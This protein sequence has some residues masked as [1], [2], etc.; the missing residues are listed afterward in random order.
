MNELQLPLTATLDSSFHTQHP[1]LIQTLQEADFH[2]VYG[3]LG[4]ST[5]EIPPHGAVMIYTAHTLS[6]A[7]TTTKNDLQFQQFI[8][9]YA[10]GVVIVEGFERFGEKKRQFIQHLF[11]R[12]GVE[13]PDHFPSFIPTRS[14]KDTV[15]CIRSI[16][17]REQRVDLPPPLSRVKSASKYLHKAQEF[18]IEGLLQVGNKKAQV[19]LNRF[20]TPWNIIQTLINDPEKIIEI[21]GFGQQFIA[22][23]RPL[24]MSISPH[25]S[26]P[27]SP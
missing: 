25:A 26:D 16:A 17:K 11:L 12:F 20:D 3:D 21:K 1:K 15:A 8:T 2:L 22:K 4:P 14:V 13:S 9:K 19:L 18:F 24:L 5:I 27:H 7:K 23:N 10:E 6:L